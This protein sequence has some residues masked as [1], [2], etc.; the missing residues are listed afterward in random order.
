MKY[1]YQPDDGFTMLFCGIIGTIASVFL[2]VFSVAFE[3][4]AFG[5]L[6]YVILSL[7]SALCFVV[8]YAVHG[9]EVKQ[10]YDPFNTK[11]LIR[12][13]NIHTISVA[14]SQ[15]DKLEKEAM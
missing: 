11:D 10:K 3:K 9:H 6:T 8:A 2:L 5:I 15:W 7:M 14:N 13:N 1:Y 4:I 12:Y